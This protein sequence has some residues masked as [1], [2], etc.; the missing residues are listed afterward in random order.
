MAIL[1]A[2]TTPLSDLAEFLKPFAALVRR[3]ESRH[4]M[5]RYATGLLSDLPSTTLLYEISST[6]S[7]FGPFT[8][9]LSEQFHTAL[10]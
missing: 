5:E 7:S 3:P 6:Q 8:F 9:A 2:G 1:K 10:K 4:A